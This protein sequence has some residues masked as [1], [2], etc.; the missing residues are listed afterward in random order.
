[1][2]GLPHC[3][4]CLLLLIN[5]S[6]SLSFLFSYGVSHYRERSLVAE[7]FFGFDQSLGIGLFS[8]WGS[9]AASLDSYSTHL[10]VFVPFKPRFERESPHPTD[11]CMHYIAFVL[12]W[13][14]ALVLFLYLSFLTLYLCAWEPPPPISPLLFPNR[15][16]SIPLFS[17]QDAF[18]LLRAYY[19]VWKSST[20]RLKWALKKWG[21]EPTWI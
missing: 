12:I 5:L 13:K 4:S 1:M 2:G 18:W 10:S 16:R 3:N 11:L 20:F 6:L 9:G 17:S 7:F 15:L 19:I 14:R 21:F 8:D